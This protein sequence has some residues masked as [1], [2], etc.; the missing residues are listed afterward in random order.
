MAPLDAIIQSA[1]R[2]NR[3][4]KLEEGLVVV[5]DPED[6]STPLGLYSESTRRT[7]GLLARLDDPE[8]LAVDYSSSRST[9]SV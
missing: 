6:E 4:G 2:C 1:G 8:R 5:F 7:R 3:E 9:I